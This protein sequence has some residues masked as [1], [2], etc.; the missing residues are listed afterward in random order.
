MF[1]IENSICCNLSL[2]IYSTKSIGSNT[3]CLPIEQ[4][5][6]AHYGVQNQR[7]ASLLIADMNPEDAKHRN[8][9]QGD[10]IILS[11][12][13]ASVE[14]MANLTEIVPAGLVNIYHAYPT[15]D[16]N[17]LIAPDYGDPKSGFPGFKSWMCQA[18]KA[19]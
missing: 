4:R 18:R 1:T 3:A 12:D 13:R 15:A 11:I 10:K 2:K 7:A 8:I 5:R 6:Q 14:V 19:L 9:S 16:V 17:T